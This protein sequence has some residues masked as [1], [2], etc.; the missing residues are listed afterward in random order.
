MKELYIYLDESGDLGVSKKASKNFVIGAISVTSPV[1]IN[2]VLKRIR[3]NI[4]KKKERKYGEFKF[5]KS[6]DRIR[7]I[8]LKRINPFVDKIN[9]ILVKKDRA[10]LTYDY[11]NLA[12][13]LIMLVIENEKFNRLNII[14]DRTLPK[15]V[16]KKF[17]ELLLISIG[18]EDKGSKIKIEH[19]DSNRVN[20]LQATDF[21][22]GSI[23][24]F[25]KGNSDYYNLIK[26]KI[27]K[28]VTI[29]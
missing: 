29:E 16:I 7:K 11:T 24:Y 25:H 12:V 5:H 19:L 27:R 14:L 15:K 23:A 3:R 20:C 1:K 13:S 4:L 2:R 17:N 6:S 9:Y 28:K 18:K 10:K 22:V 26:N 21:V 8:L